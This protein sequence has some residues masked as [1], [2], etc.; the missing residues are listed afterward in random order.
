MRGTYALPFLALSIRAAADCNCGYTISAP[1]SEKSATF[2]EVLETDF[3]HV[4]HFQSDWIAQAYNVTPANSRGPYGKSA[5][6]ENV[7]SNP[8]AS[9][10]DWSGPGIHGPNPGLELW[11][12]AHFVEIPDTD[13]QMIPMAEIVSTRNDV[14]YGSFRVGMKT[15]AVNGT[16]GAFFFYRSDS[17]EIDM[18]FLS[19]EQLQKGDQKGI[20]NLVIQSP[21]SA[22]MGY[23]GHDSADFDQHSLGFEPGSG[24]NEYRFDWFPDRVDFYANGKLLMS[25]RQNVPDAPGSI[26]LIHWSN[27]DEGWSGGP[28]GED[29]AMTVSYVKGYFNSSSA[30]TTR[31]SLRNCEDAGRMCE[32][33]NQEFP[34]DLIAGN[35]NESGRTVFLTAQSDEGDDGVGDSASSPTSMAAGEAATGIGL[36]LWMWVFVF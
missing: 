24:Y 36:L 2:T 25:T 14:L 29:A 10:Y 26:H 16:C 11:S 18:E 7:I 30:E 13:E 4:V 5:Q 32:V 31:E 35:G 3:L 20:V 12:R 22:E 19:K 33:P 23:V 15:T 9:P 27:G 34:P 28:P 17:E 6:I 8:I 21:V 1:D